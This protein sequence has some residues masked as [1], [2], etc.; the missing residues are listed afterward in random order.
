MDALRDQ[1]AGAIL[2]SCIELSLVVHAS[3]FNANT[4]DRWIKRQVPPSEQPMRDTET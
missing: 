3:T 2:L 1:R 4:A